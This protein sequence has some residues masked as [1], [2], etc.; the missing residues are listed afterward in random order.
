MIDEAGDAASQSLGSKVRPPDHPACLVAVEYRVGMSEVALFEQGPQVGTYSVFSGESVADTCRRST[1]RPQCRAASAASLVYDS[2]N[3][4][5]SVDSDDYA[6]SL[7][8]SLNCHVYLC[9]PHTKAI[10]V[11]PLVLSWNE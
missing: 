6:I 2:I 8:R 4:C 5:R 7:M 1:L 3:N 10:A 9:V 11:L